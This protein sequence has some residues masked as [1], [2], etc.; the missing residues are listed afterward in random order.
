VYGRLSDVPA[1][2]LRDHVGLKAYFDNQ[3][4]AA[5][6]I[7]FGLEPGGDTNLRALL[8]RSDGEVWLRPKA[9][10]ISDHTYRNA[11]D[12]NVLRVSICRHV[13]DPGGTVDHPIACPDKSW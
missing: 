12:W 5:Q 10:G 8:V 4:A 13:V 6:G 7:A 9:D 3:W 1:P 2:P 11:N